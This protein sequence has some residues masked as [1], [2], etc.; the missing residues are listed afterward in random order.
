V[1]WESDCL[2]A[3][4]LCVYYRALPNIRLSL[5]SQQFAVPFGAG[6]DGRKLKVLII[7]TSDSVK[8]GFVLKL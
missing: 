1:Y 6:V 8:I 7:V 3:V 2:H 5:L 4:Q